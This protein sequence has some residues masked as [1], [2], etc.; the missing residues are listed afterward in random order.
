MQSASF[1]RS[2]ILSWLPYLVAPYFSTLP[3]KGLD[4]G[5]NVTEHK[6]CVLSFSTT[7]VWSIYHSTKNSARY[8]HKYKCVHTT[9][10]L[11]LSYFNETFSRK[12]IKYHENPSSGSRVVPR[13]KKGMT[14]LTV[15]FRNFAHAQNKMGI[16]DRKCDCIYTRQI[17]MYQ[18]FF[19]EFC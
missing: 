19:T 12:Y 7:Y 11:F 15:A 8:Y 3:Y 13:G 17:Y 9:Y 18:I 4:F 6:V 14:K 10:S 2:N 16:Q 1:L 5:K